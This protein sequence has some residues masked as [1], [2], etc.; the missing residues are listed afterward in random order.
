MGNVASSEHIKVRTQKGVRRVGEM[1]LNYQHSTL[2]PSTQ[3]PWNWVLPLWLLC[4]AFQYQQKRWDK[5]VQARHPAPSSG[6]FRIR[7]S[8]YLAR[9]LGQSIALHRGP[10]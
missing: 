6:K 8:T 5:L 3:F 10:C 1:V 7:I 4:S 2:I 9:F